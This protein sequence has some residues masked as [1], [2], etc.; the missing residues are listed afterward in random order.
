MSRSGYSDDMDDHWA[1]IRWRGAVNSAISGKRGQQALREIAA[2]MDAMPEKRL[3]TNELEADGEFCTLGVLGQARGVDLKSV[4][5]EDPEA[6]AELF[7]LSP[8]MVREIVYENDEQVSEDSHWEELQG[9]P[10]PRFPWQRS[11]GRRVP[12]L[13]AAE[14]RWAYMRQW[15][16]GHIKKDGAA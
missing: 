14:K 7:N 1:H 15:V 2:A 10:D 13:Q 3:T 5:P 12:D 16:E 9:P 6:V 4:D 8:A 11:V